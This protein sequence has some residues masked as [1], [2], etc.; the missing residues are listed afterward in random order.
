M[1][2]FTTEIKKAL[3]KIEERLGIVPKDGKFIYK[4]TGASVRKAEDRAQL[5]TIFDSI[6]DCTLADVERMIQREDRSDDT[7]IVVP[8]TQIPILD[9]RLVRPEANQLDRDLL[10]CLRVPYA[11]DR[12]AR[13][14]A[15]E[16]GCLVYVEGQKATRVASECLRVS[17]PQA[18][19]SE[20]DAKKARYQADA[21]AALLQIASECT[22]AGTPE[23]IH[24]RLTD[25]ML[26]HVPTC[27]IPD[28]KRLTD[29][30]QIRAIKRGRGEAVP[31]EVVGWLDPID[32]LEKKKS[33]TQNPDFFVKNLKSLSNDP[34]ELA[35]THIDLTSL[36]DGETPAW[37]EMR[38]KFTDDEWSVLCAYIYATFD[39]TN[40]SRQALV[41]YDN[42]HTGK[43]T[44]F[45]VLA[46]ALGGKEN[47]AYPDPLLSPKDDKFYTS[48][49]YGKHVVF[50]PDC[51]NP[52]L[53]R[54]G[55][56]HSYTGGDTVSI[57]YK[58]RNAFS[59]RCYGKAYIATNTI[60]SLDVQAE[61]IK[62]RLI[63]LRPQLT[64][65]AIERL[66]Q[67]D[68]NG[69][70]IRDESG[71]IL[72]KGDPLFETHL[73]EEFWAFLKKC[74]AF[75]DRLCPDGCTIQLPQSV[76]ENNEIAE[77]IVTTQIL[78]LCDELFTFDQ[79]SDGKARKCP[80]KDFSIAV[81]EALVRLP[82]RG[83][84]CAKVINI[85]SENR[86]VVKKKIRVGEKTV[87]GLV[88]LALRNSAELDDLFDPNTPLRLSDIDTSD[89]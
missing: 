55:W 73:K 48:Q 76:R 25:W 52:N 13:T 62:T 81:E 69:E 22:K 54:T 53:L 66:G 37:D 27:M 77:D 58:G 20:I 45:A 7:A 24:Q 21:N 4:Q 10:H 31:C 12:E 84:D 63:I 36:P 9:G 61:H 74:R 34:S 41:L 87:Q 49:Y 64:Q 89:L 33:I 5:D 35:I 56:I 57:Q 46:W 38:Q 88:G 28:Q 78:E 71:K 43:S 86:G 8:Q 23:A 26:D 72:I 47:C 19:V 18:I 15:R 50:I 16:D 2:D 17:L 80:C 1:P 39:M 14:I 30:L 82:I 29:G 42:G 79:D 65:E 40:F 51:K 83:V 68:S 85:L 44:L 32:A 67:R 6:A 11:E 59:A 70:F 75:Y 60:P 3:Q